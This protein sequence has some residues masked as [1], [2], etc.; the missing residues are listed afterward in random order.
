M[1]T[2]IFKE[3]LPVEQSHVRLGLV[4]VSPMILAMLPIIEPVPGC[5]ELLQVFVP[6]FL[7]FVVITKHFGLSCELIGF[8]EGA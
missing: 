7:I 4:T 2:L 6:D 8:V 3:V 1:L 5:F